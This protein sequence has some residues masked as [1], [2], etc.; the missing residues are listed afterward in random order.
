[1]PN[2]ESEKLR[3]SNITLLPLKK[4]MMKSMLCRVTVMRLSVKKNSNTK[5]LN[6]SPE[7]ASM[8]FSGLQI[9]ANVISDNEERFHPKS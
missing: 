1:M 3:I 6:W 5:L 4:R 9:V 8:P 2:Y 7:Q